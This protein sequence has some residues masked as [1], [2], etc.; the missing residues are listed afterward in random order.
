MN[1]RSGAAA[2]KHLVRDTFRQ[3]WSSGVCGMMLA[4]TAVCA[5]LCLSVDVSGDVS[6]RGGD[7]P[8]LFLPPAPTN[9]EA[10]P[11]E[12]SRQVWATL[13]AGPDA[14]RKEGIE[15]IRGR[16]ILA[17]GAVSF[18]VSRERGD[19]V[20]LLELLLAGGIAGTF[21]LLLA[22][23]WTAGF[24]P[25]F[26]EPGAAA[27]LLAKPIARRQLLVG[28]YLGVL[29]FVAFQVALFVLSTWLALGVRTG[30]WDMTYWW[31]IPLLLL[32]FAVFY[33]FSVFLAVVTR[34]TVACVFGSLLFWLL[35]W[36]INYGSVMARSPAES[37]YLPSFTLASADVA[38]WIS[39]KPIDAGLI[40][41]NAMDADHHF[42]KP[43]AFRR[44]ESWPAFSPRLSILSSLAI[45]GVLLALSGH[46]FDEQDY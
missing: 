42:E 36:G 22:L 44:L 5:A 46:E 26:L 27:V 12:A 2:W 45:A 8:V 16:V 7:E 38:Y 25:T 11:G 6:L 34:S 14:A 20:H 19:A 30:V 1:A 32:E 31:C 21:G 40:L 17:F 23:V 37:R 41:F 4:V 24:I 3:A 43:T 13:H 9:P 18:P 33:G 39:P 10:P 29:A 28:K 15:T 35:S